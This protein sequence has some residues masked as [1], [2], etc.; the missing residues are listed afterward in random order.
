MM[1][2][3]KSMAR[4]SL[5]QQSRGPTRARATRELEIQPGDIAILP[6]GTG[7]RRLRASNDLLVV[8]AYPPTGEYEEYRATKEEH[9]RALAK[10]IN[11]ALP[12]SDPV[13]GPDGPLVRLWRD[14]R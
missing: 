9:D 8:G 4:A 3:L 5:R 6:A 14:A 2:G 7:H 11:V 10:I 1:R 13:Y 12:Q